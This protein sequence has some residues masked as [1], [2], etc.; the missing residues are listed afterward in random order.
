MPE[1]AAEGIDQPWTD[2]AS[3]SPQPPSRDTVVAMLLSHLLPALQQFDADG[4]APFLPRYA[5]LDALA[6]RELQVH[7]GATSWPARALGIAGD[8]ALRVRDAD[9]RE[10]HVHAGDVSV[11]A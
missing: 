3:L 6:G 5:A 8:G 9:G 1:G 11:R 2:L 4:L 10:R 7:E